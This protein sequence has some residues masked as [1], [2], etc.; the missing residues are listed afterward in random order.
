MCHC[1]PDVWVSPPLGYAASEGMV[2]GACGGR[3]PRC[4][5]G[6]T[7]N[8]LHPTRRRHG[9]QSEAALRRDD[10]PR[11][12]QDR[13]AAQPRLARLCFPVWGSA[14]VQ[15][16]AWATRQLRGVNWPFAWG[17][18][19][20]RQEMTKADAM[21]QYINQVRSSLTPT[22][23]VY[24]RSQFATPTV[25]HPTHL[26]LPGR[27]RRRRAV[28]DGSLRR[29]H[30]HDDTAVSGALPER[31]LRQHLAGTVGWRPRP[32]SWCGRT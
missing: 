21:K 13:R 15:V 32:T 14:G 12:F 2:G 9:R 4:P 26:Q 18:S 3:S 24:I 5:C 30:R 19:P 22:E 1:A 23:L 16:R 25:K 11:C 17:R 31:S 27:R 10:R 8:A 20:P 6:R 29:E 7:T 28:C